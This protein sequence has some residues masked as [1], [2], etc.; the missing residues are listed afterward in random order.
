[1]MMK[2][3]SPTLAEK[4]PPDLHQECLNVWNKWYSDSRD[5]GQDPDLAETTAYGKT[6][7]WIKKITNVEKAKVT[8]K[9][10]KFFQFTKIDSRT[11]TVSGIF[12]DETPDKTDEICD[13]DSSKPHYQ[14]WSGEFAKN[15]NG[16]S[17]GNVRE[18]HGLSA[19]G[20]VTDMVF[21]D[22]NKTIHGTVMVVDEPAWQKCLH[23]V[24]TGFSHGGDYVG[25]LRSEQGPKG[26]TYKRYTA[27][28]SELSLVDNPANPNA[29][30]QFIKA[31]GSVELRKFAPAQ[32]EEV[33]MEENEEMRKQVEGY[34]L[35]FLTKLGAVSSGTSVIN[36]G[37]P[38]TL[39][40]AIPLVLGKVG[41]SLCPACSNPEEKCTC[42]KPKELQKEED[43]KPYGDVNYA[44]PGHQADKKKRYPLDTET[45]IRA[46]WNYI[47]QAKN[48]AKY[49]SDEVGSI[50]SKIVAAWKE[51]VGGDGPPSAEKM[52]HA[53]TIIFAK[54]LETGLGATPEQVEKLFEVTMKMEKTWGDAAR[55]A[56]AEV[57][58]AAGGL[59]AE[60]ADIAS[61]GRRISEATNT[62]SGHDL[63]QKYHQRKA[64]EMGTAAQN[65]SSDSK[66]A[67][68]Y[69]NLQAQHENAA[70]LHGEAIKSPGGKPSLD[71]TQASRDVN[72][73]HADHYW[74]GTKPELKKGMNQ[75]SRLAQLL[76]DV[77]WLKW[78]V[79]QEQQAEG[80][81]SSPLPASL[82]ED[83]SSLASTLIAMVG[84]ETKELIES[85]SEG[86]PP[87]EA[88]SPANSCGPVPFYC[89]MGDEDE[90]QK[91]IIDA[92]GNVP[93]YL[94]TQERG[95]GGYP[96][97][98]VEDPDM[99]KPPDDEK[100]KNG[101]MGYK[102]LSL[103]NDPNDETEDPNTFV[104]VPQPIPPTDYT[105]FRV[106]AS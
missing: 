41:T 77:A 50:K 53:V 18:M 98:G 67:Q 16:A 78:V 84:E 34:T 92:G 48:A 73:N 94:T 25:G 101:Y 70:A 83:V 43:K 62:P 23:N 19:V 57:R 15:T 56:A 37:G 11:R 5:D 75:V 96:A 90:L 6:Y 29:H 60:E 3:L 51:K 2:E 66:I 24:Y 10:R 71:A 93:F 54:A 72:A 68:S 4:L 47:H 44:D 14:D 76:L 1:M 30:F 102:P 33:V 42:A 20:K 99:G 49:S 91:A 89:A 104:A 80:D 7:E 79:A 22:P 26:K 38:V 100:S 45:H 105:F 61:S 28:P 106:M 74:K 39:T 97:T 52:A 40:T 81:E 13:Y 36:T 46:A 69:K 21:D 87:E 59:S 65:F 55:E 63:A 12:T 35:S 95:Y 86:K 27:K 82:Q 17:L 32:G 9:F 88:S 103:A 31:D 64:S 58:H 85:L 8:M